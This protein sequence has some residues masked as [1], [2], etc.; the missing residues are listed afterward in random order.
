MIFSTD[1]VRT[2]VVTRAARERV[3]I[4][5]LDAR[6]MENFELEGLQ[7]SEPTEKLLL[8]VPELLQPERRVLFG[9]RSNSSLI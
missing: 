9:W 5:M 8:W 3:V 1:A 6:P 4:L 2:R 7:H